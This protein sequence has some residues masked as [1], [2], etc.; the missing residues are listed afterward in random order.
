MQ[1][2]S[3]PVEEIRAYIVSEFGGHQGKFAK[4]VGYSGA[5]ISDVLSRKRPP[6]ENLLSHLGMVR[7]VVKTV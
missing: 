4:S 5:Y 2:V 7:V 6:S 3:D 1:T